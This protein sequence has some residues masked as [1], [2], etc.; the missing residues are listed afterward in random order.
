MRGK[1]FALLSVVFFGLGVAEG[2]LFRVG[3]DLPVSQIEN[4]IL[5][6]LGAAF[7]ITFFLANEPDASR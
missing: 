4:L 5:L 6:A 7:L 3:L 2:R 1:I